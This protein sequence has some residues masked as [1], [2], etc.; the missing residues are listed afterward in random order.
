M[1]EFVLFVERN[2]GSVGFADFEEEA[3][4]T[5]AAE[6]RDGFVEERFGEAGAALFW[7]DAEIQEFGFGHHG[8]DDEKAGDFAGGFVFDDPAEFAALVESFERFYGPRGGF[9]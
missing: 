6:F 9:R 2:C 3:I 5:G 1:A 4:D 8:L 7:S